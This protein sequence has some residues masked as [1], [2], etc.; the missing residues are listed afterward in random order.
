MVRRSKVSSFVI[1]AET[2]EGNGEGNEPNEEGCVDMERMWIFMKNNG[3]EVVC[4]NREA[5]RC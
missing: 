2:K 5:A 4:R 1:R 3:R